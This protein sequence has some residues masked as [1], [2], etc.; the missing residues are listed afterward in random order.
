MILSNLVC[1]H[2]MA[3]QICQ[4]SSCTSFS[5]FGTKEVRQLHRKQNG[6]IQG[7]FTPLRQCP[8]DRHQIH[9]DPD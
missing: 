4:T 5:A 3:D 8:Q 2:Y 7:V 6:V 9:L 1:S